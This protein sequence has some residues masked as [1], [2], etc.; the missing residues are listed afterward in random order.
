MW[1][2]GGSIRLA[3]DEARARHLERRAGSTVI[4][5]IP[6][7]AICVDPSLGEATGRAGEVTAVVR[8]T[9]SQGDRVFHRIETADGHSLLARGANRNPLPPAM[10]CRL[11]IDASEL[12][13]F[14]ADGAGLRLER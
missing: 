5:G 8:V 7:Q 10:A 9:E 6:P 4:A 12:H 1:F 3:L 13:F 14:E 11:Q 2:N